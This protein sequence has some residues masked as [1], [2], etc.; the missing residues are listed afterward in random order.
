MEQARVLFCGPDGKVTLHP[1]ELKRMVF[2]RPVP[3]GN[4]RKIPVMYDLPNV[5]LVPLK[6]QTPVLHSP[7]GLSQ[8]KQEAS[9]SIDCELPTDSPLTEQLRQLDDYVNEAAVINRSSWFP[10]LQPPKW[11]DND[12]GKFHTAITR[13][14]VR[15]K[16]GQIFPPLLGLK[17]APRNLSVY[18]QDK[19]E[20]KMES[21]LI[22]DFYFRAVV[23]IPWVWLGEK[24]STSLH[25]VQIQHQP[26][27]E[28][29]ATN[30]HCLFFD[31]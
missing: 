9:F 31:P 23:L 14:R 17:V 11:T 30:T 7:W 8:F 3:Q 22:K 29:T 12:I 10:A 2:E 4:A 24:F 26:R 20:V 5:G 21:L 25:A 19:K 6:L 27:P 13:D 1:F 28:I 16:D 15:K 18:S